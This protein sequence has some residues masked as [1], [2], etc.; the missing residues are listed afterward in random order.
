MGLY[1][2]QL[3]SGGDWAH[4]PFRLSDLKNIKNDLEN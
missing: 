1:P 4:V 3:I 2:F